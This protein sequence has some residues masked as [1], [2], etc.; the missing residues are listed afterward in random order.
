MTGFC[1]NPNFYPRTKPHTTSSVVPTISTK[2]ALY[3]AGHFNIAS[4]GLN[5]KPPRHTLHKVASQGLHLSIPS[6]WQPTPSFK[7]LTSLSSTPFLCYP[8]HLSHTA[9]HTAH[10]LNTTSGQEMFLIHHCS[11]QAHWQPINSVQ[12]GKQLR[13]YPILSLLSPNLPTQ[14]WHKAHYYYKS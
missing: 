10:N 7:I 8:G 12:A 6:F 5:F 2:D 4:W 3:L 11:C 13:L 1:C 9:S 14:N